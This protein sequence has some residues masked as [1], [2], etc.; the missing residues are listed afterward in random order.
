MTQK[1]GGNG[2]DPNSPLF[3]AAQKACQSNRGSGG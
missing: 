3:Q 2:L 1:S